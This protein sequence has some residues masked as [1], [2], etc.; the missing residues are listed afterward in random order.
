M[1]SDSTSQ[2][3]RERSLFYRRVR[4][5]VAPKAPS[6]AGSRGRHKSTVVISREELRAYKRE[7]QQLRR[8]IEALQ[9]RLEAIEALH[10]EAEA[11]RPTE[12]GGVPADGR[13]GMRGELKSY[14]GSVSAMLA[15]AE[16]RAESVYALLDAD[17]DML[18]AAT[19]AR[20]L[21]VSVQALHKKR[22]AGVVLG[23]SQTTRKMWFPRWQVLP[24]VKLLDGLAELHRVFNGDAWTVYRFLD[25]Q[26]H[27]GL[28]GRTGREAL[29]A[30]EKNNVLTVAQSL[31]EAGYS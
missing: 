4:S 5:V 20:L 16:A 18:D 17:P 9:E 26:T 7:R 11:P 15:E 3:A 19:F 10:R 12:L 30:G 31:C 23:L 28:G 14:R 29:I 21:G 2:E 22:K 6:F 25:Q 24:G 27:P 8:Q 13:I 1:L